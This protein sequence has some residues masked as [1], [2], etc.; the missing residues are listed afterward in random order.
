MKLKFIAV[1][2]GLVLA[3]VA[4]GAPPGTPVVAHQ[5][6]PGKFGSWPVTV[7][8]SVYVVTD[9]GFGGGSSGSAY[10]AC[11]TPTSKI[12]SVGVTSGNTPS[13][14]LTSRKSITLCNSLQNTGTPLVKCRFDG[15]APVM[16][17]SNP[18]DVLGVGDCITYNLADT[19]VPQCIA[20]AA[21]TYV[22][23]LEC[24]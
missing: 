17:A 8:G 10:V 24:T 5:G 22:T 9:G 7:T 12:T 18:G 13:T 4:V 19:V 23:S 1:T 3:A 2:A 6:A 15:V 11:T 14:Q 21:A 16:T 20:D